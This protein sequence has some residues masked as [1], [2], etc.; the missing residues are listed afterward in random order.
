MCKLYSFKNTLI[1]NV[2]HKKAF[3]TTNYDYFYIYILFIQYINL[4]MRI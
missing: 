4:S 2:M 1:K 3:E